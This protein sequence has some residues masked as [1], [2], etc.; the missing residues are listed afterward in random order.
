MYLF[1]NRAKHEQLV[2][3]IRERIKKNPSSLELSLQPMKN[4]KILQAR[5]IQVIRMIV[6]QKKKIQKPEVI[7][8]IIK[9]TII[10]WGMSQPMKLSLD[11]WKDTDHTRNIPRKN[12]SEN[13][14]N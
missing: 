13:G 11:Q 1:L 3:N 14:Q 2:H 4:P 7:T 10:T 8:V 6:S 12:K 5:L 9:N